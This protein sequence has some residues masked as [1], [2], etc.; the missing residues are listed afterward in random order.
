MGNYPSILFTVYVEHERRQ[1]WNLAQAYWR[2][3]NERWKHY[4]TRQASK[5]DTNVR[6]MRTLAPHTECLQN[7]WSFHVVSAALHRCTLASLGLRGMH[8]ASPAGRTRFYPFTIATQCHWRWFGQMWMLWANRIW[9]RGC[10]SVRTVLFPS[11]ERRRMTD[12]SDSPPWTVMHCKQ[13]VRSRVCGIVRT[14]PMCSGCYT[15]TI[16]YKKPHAIRDSRTIDQTAHPNAQTFDAV[17]SFH[18]I[19]LSWSA[20]IFGCFFATTVLIARVRRMLH[21][22]IANKFVILLRIFFF[23]FSNKKYWIYY[24]YSRVNCVVNRCESNGKLNSEKWTISFELKIP[25]ANDDQIH[26]LKK[27]NK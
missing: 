15:L 20:L 1:A 2:A 13:F 6:S 4:S 23:F 9:N 3:P 27:E 14:T 5:H 22:R 12:R 18:R 21:V 19:S 24:Y 7:K 8:P 17:L 25:C 11:P 26:K 16:A 10:S